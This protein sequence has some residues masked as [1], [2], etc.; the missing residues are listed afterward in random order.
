MKRIAT[1]PLEPT[2]SSGFDYF[3]Y[4]EA[5]RLVGIRETGERSHADSPRT[6]NV[7]LRCESFDN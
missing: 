2:S 5:S 1:N 3:S 4:Q 7:A 6:V